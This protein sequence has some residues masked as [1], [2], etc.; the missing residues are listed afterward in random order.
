M[1]IGT[2]CGEAYDEAAAS[3]CCGQS[4]YEKLA[5]RAERRIPSLSVHCHQGCFRSEGTRMCNSNKNL[6]KGHHFI[7]FGG[8]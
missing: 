5:L 7:L 1:F 2:V 6:I 3:S 8:P 4:L